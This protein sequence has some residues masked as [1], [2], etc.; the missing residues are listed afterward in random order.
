MTEDQRGDVGQLNGLK[1]RSRS[2]RLFLASRWH[3]LAA[4][5]SRWR[6]RSL[7]LLIG[8][9]GTLETSR[10]WIGAWAA[11]LRPV[12]R[13]CLASERVAKLMALVKKLGAL[14]LKI[15]SRYSWRFWVHQA[16]HSCQRGWMLVRAQFRT[17]SNW[18]RN[19]MAGNRFLSS[20]RIRCSVLA[21]QIGRSEGMRWVRGACRRLW[22]WCGH[23]ARCTEPLTSAWPSTGEITGRTAETASAEKG[24]QEAGVWVDS[25]SP[26]GLARQVWSTRA[27]DAYLFASGNASLGNILWADGDCPIGYARIAAEYILP[28]EPLLSDPAISGP[29]VAEF[30]PDQFLLDLYQA[31]SE[32]LE[33]RGDG[34]SRLS[35]VVPLVDVFALFSSVTAVSPD[36]TPDYTKDDFIK[37]V[38]RLH[39]SGVDTTR[40]G[41]RISFPISRGVKGKI[42]TVTD[43]AGYERRYYGV[44]FLGQGGSG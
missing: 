3:R 24:I 11:G 27:R 42:M 34:S 7:H 8:L 14:I 31:Y 15:E 39:A 21:G 19:W 10:R 5:D 40:H 43:E 16:G 28:P 13:D 1:R 20:L 26:L 17:G 4:K 44:R 36:Y 9:I 32:L 33:Q 12:I 22:R 2:L 18:L 30:Q 6:A 29:E 25:E 37:D 23:L 38:Y 35:P 41:A